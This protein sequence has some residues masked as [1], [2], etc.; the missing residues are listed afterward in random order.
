M[1]YV[2]GAIVFL[3]W[4]GILFASATL[5]MDTISFGDGWFDNDL[6]NIGLAIAGLI[7]CIASAFWVVGSSE[8]KPCVKYDTTYQYNAATKTTMPVQYCAVEGEWVK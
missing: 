2:L 7:A 1:D 6:L 3:V 8:D 4:M 5:L